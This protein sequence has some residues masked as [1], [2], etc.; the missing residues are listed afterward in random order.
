[1]QSNNETRGASEIQIIM[2][3]WHALLR[4]GHKIIAP[5]IH[6]INGESDLISITKA[7]YVYEY[8][9]KTNVA[10]FQAEFR[11][12]KEKHAGL[13]GEKTAYKWKYGYTKEK[14]IE[15]GLAEFR[16]IR[17]PN[18][19]S[20]VF[21]EDM[22]EK[23]DVPDYAGIY[24]H[25]SGYWSRNGIKEVRK[26]NKVRRQAIC[27]ENTL[28]EISKKLSVRLFDHY[29]KKYAPQQRYNY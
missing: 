19:F 21:P 14:A 15:L 4:K 20:F 25:A 1:M 5:N 17:V 3:M 2:S 12:K 7:G 9:I 18:Y 26:P 6:L 29:I 10:D 27:T 16:E 13:R 24:L 8:E 11:G 28:K 22:Y 23:V